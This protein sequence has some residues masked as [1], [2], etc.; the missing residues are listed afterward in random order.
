M[1]L[2]SLCTIAST[3]PKNYALLIWDNE[4]HQTTGGQ[5]TAT[6]ARTSLAA[7]AR[8]AGIEKAFEVR[9]EEELRRIYDR[10][11]A[12]DGPFVVSVKIAA[13][14]STGRFDRDV[15]GHA[16]RFRRAV[17]ELPAR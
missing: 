15:L 14:P 2:G 3:A 9:T 16:R 7:I 13:G 12:D 11:L 17:A 5:P 4:V 6:A 1:N 10:I 8:G